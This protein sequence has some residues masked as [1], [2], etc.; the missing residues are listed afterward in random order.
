M[1]KNIT[2][3]KFKNEFWTK[4]YVLVKN[5][6]SEAT[7]Q[8]MDE[9]AK[10]LLGSDFIDSY[11]I[12]TWF[13]KYAFNQEKLEKI[14]PVTDISKL[15]KNISENKKLAEFAS[16]ILKKKSKILK[17]RLIFK[18][19]G[20]FGYGIHQDFDYTWEN[21]ANPDD[22]LSIYIAIDDATKENGALE[23][24]P[25]HHKSLIEHTNSTIDPDMLNSTPKLM[26]MKRGDILFFHSLTPHRSNANLSNGYRKVFYTIFIAE[27]SQLDYKEQLN[28]YK[29]RAKAKVPQKS[30]KLYFK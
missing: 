12:R 16:F 2:L 17:D 22:I 9:E 13:R 19:P 11:N 7:I 4:G 27:E 24:F 29:E 30:S 20:N 21:I 3:N 5:F 15:F 25:F 8:Q 10:S 28:I 18:Q 1:D 23:F 6:F 14:E 26:E